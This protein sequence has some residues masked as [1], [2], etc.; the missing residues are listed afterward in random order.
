M[1]FTR[2]NTVL[3]KFLISISNPKVI[4]F[5]CGF[6]PGFVNL[7][8]LTAADIII[9]TCTILVA[10]TSVLAAYAFAASNIKKHMFKRSNNG[11]LN[12][13]AGGVMMAAGVSIAVKS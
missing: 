11:V 3:T 12:R 5:Y 13:V 7:S 10:I 4:A 1:V 9:I 6:L 2:K 8:K